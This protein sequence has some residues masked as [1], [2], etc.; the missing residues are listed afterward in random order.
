MYNRY[1]IK[2]IVRFSR[3]CYYICLGIVFI[4]LIFLLLLHIFDLDLQKIFPSCPFFTKSGFYCFGCGGT[5]AVNALLHGH[6]I[7]SFLYHPF[8]IY[9]V[10]ILTVFIFSHTLDIIT[11]GY[12]KGLIFNPLYFYIA[13]II[14]ILQCI[15]KNIILYTTGSLY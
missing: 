12:I 5:R 4:A 14:V 2:D 1:G 10:V 3:R 13:T 7:K 15:V 9:F 11:H 8:V 6:I